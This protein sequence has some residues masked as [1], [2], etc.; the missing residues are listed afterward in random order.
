MNM[1]NKY[2]PI[3]LAEFTEREKEFQG[4][5]VA[6]NL[7]MPRMPPWKIFHVE[8]IAHDDV[9]LAHS[10]GELPRGT[11]YCTNSIG[12]YL[13]HE[14]SLFMLYGARRMLQLVAHLQQR[15]ACDKP[16]ALIRA[17]A[18]TRLAVL[19]HDP[20]TFSNPV[21]TYYVCFMLKIKASRVTVHLMAEPATISMAHYID[22]EQESMYK[23]RWDVFD[24]SDYIRRV[25]TARV[26][27][28]DAVQI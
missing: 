8:D 18:C 12:G 17:G 10:D 2:P 14:E 19:P 5:L 27:Q 25:V 9:W 4:N 11:I 21:Q 1:K 24:E 6:V 28:L 3:S 15:Y 23:L 20:P 16:I 7:I 13:S 22:G 26:E